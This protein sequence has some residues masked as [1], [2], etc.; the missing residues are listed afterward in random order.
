[1]KRWPALDIR[2]GPDVARDAGPDRAG[3]FAAWKENGQ[4]KRWR[5]LYGLCALV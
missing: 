2:L 1:M 3:L 5:A 4:N